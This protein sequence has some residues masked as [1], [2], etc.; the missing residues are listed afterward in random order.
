LQSPGSLCQTAHLALRLLGLL[1]RPPLGAGL[2]SA[3]GARRGEIDVRVAA[4]VTQLGLFARLVSPTLAA[5][6]IGP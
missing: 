4:S 2:A 3:A 1:N 5:L 6:A